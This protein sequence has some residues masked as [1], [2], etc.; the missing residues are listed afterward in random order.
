MAGA[1]ALAIDRQVRE[2][3]AGC[4]DPTSG[5]FPARPAMGRRAES[6][7]V[8]LSDLQFGR[9][10]FGPDRVAPGRHHLRPDPDLIESPDYGTRLLSAIRRSVIRLII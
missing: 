10:S 8:G 5:A 3:R 6:D 7:P 1:L 2:R 9:P 4:A